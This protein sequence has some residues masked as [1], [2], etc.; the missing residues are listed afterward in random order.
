MGV[1]SF[2]TLLVEQVASDIK[3]FTGSL[4]KLT[5]HAVLEEK[6]SS[7]KRAFAVACAVI[8]NHANPSQAQKVIEDTA[9]LHFG[10]RNAQLSCAIMSTC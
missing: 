5:Y 1:A 7:V 3:A 10:E 2:I 6:S 8:L 9:T 4:L